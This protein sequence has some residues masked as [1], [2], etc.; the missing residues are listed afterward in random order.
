MTAVFAVVASTMMLVSCTNTVSQQQPEPEYVDNP[1][2][3]ICWDD[4]YA[5]YQEPIDLFHMECAEQYGVDP[6]SME[7][8]MDFHEESG[9]KYLVCDAYYMGD[10]FLASIEFLVDANQVSFI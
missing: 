8:Y 6:D 3:E 9:S 1:V 5:S 10:L 2:S 4:V 7:I